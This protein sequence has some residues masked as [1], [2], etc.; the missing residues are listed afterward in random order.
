MWELIFRGVLFPIFDDIYH[1]QI[2]PTSSVFNVTH[3]PFMAETEEYWLESTGVNA[4]ALLISLFSNYFVNCRFMLDKIA[5]LLECGINQINEKTAKVSVKCWQ[6]LIGNTH[7]LLEENEWNIILH[8]L[9]ISLSNSL[10]FAFDKQFDDVCVQYQQYAKQQQIEQK[11]NPQLSTNVHQRYPVPKYNPAV[12]AVQTIVHGLLLDQLFNIT[13]NFASKL[14]INQIDDN[15]ASFHKSHEFARTFNMNTNFRNFLWTT[16][17]KPNERRTSPDL[18]YQE[19][20]A[21]RIILQCLLC[22]CT[23]YI[24]PQAMK[25][26]IKQDISELNVEYKSIYHERLHSFATI[27]LDE[28]VYDSEHNLNAIVNQNKTMID[29]ML[30]RF[31]SNNTDECGMKW[32]TSVILILFECLLNE[33]QWEGNDQMMILYHL[34]D[35][36]IE[37]MVIDNREVR[38][39]I[40]QLFAGPIKNALFMKEKDNDLVVQ[41]VDCNSSNSNNSPSSTINMSTEV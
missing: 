23:H 3:P 17:H 34:Y 2:Q 10:P 21:S 16:S 30:N 20:L 41:S 32:K 36:L 33:K 37:C 26:I 12:T 35:I 6:I 7:S 22:I 8:S 27:V 40:S 25:Q 15:L 38:Y 28:F 18:Y 9:S 5:S 13:V 14:T 1:N 19:S 4:L 39:R 29:P 24:P 11:N 31:T